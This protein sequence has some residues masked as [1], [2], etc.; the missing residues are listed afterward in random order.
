MLSCELHPA[1]DQNQL[2]LRLDIVF[3]DRLVPGTLTLVF[4]GIYINCIWESKNPGDIGYN[5][6]ADLPEKKNAIWR[7]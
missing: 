2:Q 5:Q 4:I 3:G 6:F 7:R 1:L